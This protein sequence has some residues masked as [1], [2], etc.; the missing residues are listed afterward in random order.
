MKIYSYDSCVK[1]MVH[2]SITA[3]RIIQ[4]ISAVI[5]YMYYNS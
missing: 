1:F 4:E 5:T 3:K 2:Y